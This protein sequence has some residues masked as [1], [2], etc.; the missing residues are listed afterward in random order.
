MHCIDDVLIL[1]FCIKLGT[2]LYENC[3]LDGLLILNK[4]FNR[5]KKI[6]KIQLQH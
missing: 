1:T 4:Y 5:P 6:K 2:C 3:S